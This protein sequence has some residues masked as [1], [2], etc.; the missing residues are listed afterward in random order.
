MTPWRCCI[1]RHVVAGGAVGRMSGPN[2]MLDSTHFTCFTST[3]VNLRRY[4]VYLL[5]E[6]TSLLHEVPSSGYVGLH[7]ARQRKPTGSGVSMSTFVLVKQVKLQ[8]ICGATR[9]SAAEA[10]TGPGVSIRTFV[11]LKQVKLRIGQPARAP[12]DP[13]QGSAFVPLYQYSK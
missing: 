4:S 9:S 8:R 6:C 5:Y 10:Y 11:L 1:H 2:S 3:K 12:R 7:A 13:P